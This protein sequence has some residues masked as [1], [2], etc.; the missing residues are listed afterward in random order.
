MRSA[1][2]GCILLAAAIV[3]LAGLLRPSPNPTP[4]L[5]RAPL[6]AGSQSRSPRELLVGSAKSPPGG[7]AAIE[8]KLTADT[9]G[10]QGSY[11]VAT[12][13][14]A[15]GLTYGVNGNSLYRAASVNKMPI[16]ITLFDSADKGR[17]SLNQPLTLSDSDIQ[18][19]GTGTIQDPNAPRTYTL[20]QLGA[21]MIQVSDNTA[22]YVLERALGQQAVQQNAQ[23]W[24]LDHTSM[25]DNTTTPSDAAA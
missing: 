1:A 7:T 8:Q 16:L 3:A 13:D 11:G 20:R 23:R 19:Y 4:A 15:S 5:P 12:I 14:L 10:L 18:H 25:T 9:A 17:I 21:L 2:F 22:A 24:R 6:T